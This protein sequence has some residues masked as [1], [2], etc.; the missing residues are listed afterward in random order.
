MHLNTQNSGPWKGRELEGMALEACS[1]PWAPSVGAATAEGTRE[2]Q[3]Q[4]TELSPS[5]K[6]ICSMCLLFIDNFKVPSPYGLLNSKLMLL[7]GLNCDFF[8]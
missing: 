4:Q 8:F 2:T 7:C 1:E 3:G 5:E 6:G